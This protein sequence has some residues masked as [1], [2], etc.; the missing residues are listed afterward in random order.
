MPRSDPAPSGTADRAWRAP[1]RVNLIGDHTDYQDGFCLPMAIDRECRI[2]GRL[3]A[4]TASSAH[5]HA[6][7]AQLPGEVAIA[8]D[9]ST[10]P[11][12][13][14][15]PWGR[16]VAGVVQALSRRGARVPAVDVAIDSS[17]PTGSGLSRAPR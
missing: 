2:A 10:D 17:V 15:P 5:V 11:S 7:S 1:G 13:V 6:R 9:G 3:A 4:D 8:T 16:F 14:D 12:T